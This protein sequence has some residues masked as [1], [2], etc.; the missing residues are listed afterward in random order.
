LK[1]ELEHMKILLHSYEQ[2]NLKITE[3]EI[4]LR[5][6]QIKFDK[7]LKRS[8]NEYKEKISNMNKSLQCYEE[9]VN[10]RSSKNL[11]NLSFIKAISGKNSFIEEVEEEINYE[12]VRLNFI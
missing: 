9:F 11:F 4:K 10:E 8:E 6:Q 12:T 5:N 2:Q 3:L 7:E 1:G